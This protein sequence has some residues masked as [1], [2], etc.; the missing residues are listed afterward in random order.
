VKQWIQSALKA[1]KEQTGRWAILGLAVVLAFSGALWWALTPERHHIAVNGLG[2]PITFVTTAKD[3]ATALQAQGIQLHP[4]DQVSPDLST[5]LK[6]Q[7]ELTVSVKKAVTAS[8]LVDG[9]TVEAVTQAPTVAEL[10]QE[11]SVT[12]NPTDTV[13][14]DLKA[15]VTPGMSIKVVRRTQ[16]TTLVREEIPFDIERQDDRTMMVGENKEIQA[17][18][19]GI[20]EIRQVVT[21]ED[22]KQVATEVVGEAVVS[23]PVNRIVAY[24]TGGVVSRGGE[25]YRFSRELTLSATGYTAGKESN[26]DGNGYTYTGMKAVRGVVAVDPR[27]IPLYTRLY[28][29]G[30]GPAIAGDIGGAIKGNRID[31]CFDS[32]QEAL[33]WGRRDATVYILND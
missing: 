6:G 13:S 16:E 10:L 12:L 7:K 3:L 15:P 18:A 20:K 25:S 1:G 30:Y 19:P 32:L 21:Y 22:G 23:E 14:A 17:G 2:D 24:G 28:I 4:K 27:V 29:E 26:P 11:A 9:K 31:L 8:I 33:N 5:A